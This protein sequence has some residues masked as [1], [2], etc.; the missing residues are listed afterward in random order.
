MLLLFAPCWLELQGYGV[1]GSAQKHREPGH[2]LCLGTGVSRWVR[3]HPVPARV[4]GAAEQPVAAQFASQARG[5]RVE[6]DRGAEGASAS[7]SPGPGGGRG[8]AAG[9]RAVRVA[10]ARSPGGTR[11]GWS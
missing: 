4:G 2:L 1:A 11:P 3:T 5:V 8:A 9:G 10:G 6:L 7:P